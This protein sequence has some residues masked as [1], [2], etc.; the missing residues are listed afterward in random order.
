MGPV[1][2]SPRVCCKFVEAIVP[3][4]CGWKAILLLGTMH[5][6]GHQRVLELQDRF[7]RGRSPVNTE[8]WVE[9]TRREVFAEMTPSGERRA[10]TIARRGWVRRR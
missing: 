2:G 6:L 10:A 5:P 8:R 4:R 7:L 3:P 9:D 1:A